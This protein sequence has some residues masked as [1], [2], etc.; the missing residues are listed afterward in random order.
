MATLPMFRLDGRVALVS[1][2]GRGIGAAT[3]LGLA[4]A[5][6]DVAVLSRTPE[7]IESVVKQA[8]ELGRRAV[9]IPTDAGDPDAVSAAVA[10]AADELGRLDVVVSVTGGSMP[11]PFTDTHDEALRK[12]FE[13]NVV[14]GVRLVREAVPH[15]ARSDSASV[16]MVSS[17]TGHLVGRGYLA[18]GAAK[19]SLDHAVRMMAADLNPNIRVNAVAPGAILTEALE[20]VAADPTMK[21]TLEEHTPL[22]RIGTPEDVA[23]A[24]LY[25]ASP[26]SSYVTGQV[27]AVDGGLVTPNM[28]LPI[29]DV[30][31]PT[32][33]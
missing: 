27:L 14:H 10:R 23:A 31:P 33:T 4:E 21:A 15:L 32:N 1:G 25:L 18:Y 13:N 8:R 12:S 29:P 26:A 9:A 3:A 19:A 7:Q 22:R 17:S 20:V 5:G 28:P 11:R 2:A 6:A 30:E 24:I 16:V